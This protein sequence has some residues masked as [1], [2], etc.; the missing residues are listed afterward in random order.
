MAKT[1]EWQVSSPPVFNFDD[2]A[3]VGG[4]MVRRSRREARDHARRG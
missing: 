2:P 1:I 3:G 4:L